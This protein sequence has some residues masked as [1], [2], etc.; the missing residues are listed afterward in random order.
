MI[1]GDLLGAGLALSQGARSTLAAVNGFA[2][3]LR[4]L[5]EAASATSWSGGS[6]SSAM[7]PF[8]PTEDVDARSR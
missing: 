6:R 7:G 8:G 4:A 5:N 1:V 2:M 3:A